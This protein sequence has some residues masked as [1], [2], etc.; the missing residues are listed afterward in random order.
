MAFA[1]K[2]DF[3]PF[4]I[5]IIA[6]LNDGTVMTISLDRVK[7]SLTPDHWDLVEIFS[8]A[9]AYGLY[10]A[11]STIALLNVIWET[12]FFEDTFGVTAYHDDI[13]AHELHMII[14]LQV[15]MISQALIFC[16]RSQ[17]WSWMERPSIWLLAA[18]GIAQLI[19]S[20]IAAYAD[21][22]FT[23]VS[24]ISGGWI[25]IIWVWNIIW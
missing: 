8:Y 5:L 15:A 19:A 3:P 7:P 12:S 2:F 23:L 1:Y 16:T 6:L 17:G 18:F 22:G 24:P 14:Y 20:I 9:I 4:M 21:W 10:L 11:A 25:G 13:N